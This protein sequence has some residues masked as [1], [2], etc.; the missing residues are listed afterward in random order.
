MAI[1]G[2]FFSINENVSSLLVVVVFA[3]QESLN[4]LGRLSS[5]SLILEIL[6]LKKTQNIFAN[7]VF[8]QHKTERITQAQT[9]LHSLNCKKY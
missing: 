1:P 8:E 5:S 9:Y 4:P 2:S 3:T 7:S 6:L